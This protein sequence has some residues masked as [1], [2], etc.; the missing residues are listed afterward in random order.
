M[1]VT[2]QTWAKQEKLTDKRPH[3]IAK[4]GKEA[5]IQV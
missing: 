3:R 2:D 5:F 1:V 4:A